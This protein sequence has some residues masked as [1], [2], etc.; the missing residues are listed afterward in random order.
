MKQFKKSVSL[1]F[2]FITL[3]FSV[4]CGNPIDGVSTSFDL[5]EGLYG[6]DIY[7]VLRW[8]DDDELDKFHYHNYSSLRIGYTYENDTMPIDN[9]RFKV[10]YGIFEDWFY[11]DINLGYSEKTFSEEIDDYVIRV[12]FFH[13][14]GRN[15]FSLKYKS[16]EMMILEKNLNINDINELNNFKVLNTII[17]H[18]SF[19]SVCKTEYLDTCIF[20]FLLPIERINLALD[21]NNNIYEYHKLSFKIELIQLGVDNQLSAEYRCYRFANLSF[22]IIGDEAIITPEKIDSVG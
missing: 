10:Y 4:S 5:P 20:D 3:F 17:E 14:A 8:Y 16:G 21:E 9:I 1:F 18:S 13:S 11:N 6:G 15:Q 22:R 19:A 2:Y 12:S 7:S